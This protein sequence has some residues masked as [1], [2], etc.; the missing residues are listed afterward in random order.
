MAERSQ[1]WPTGTTGDGTLAIS[2][3]QTLEWFRDLFTPHTAAGPN[4]VQGILYG[5]L[6]NLKVTPTLPDQSPVS[7]AAG[8]AVVEGF[9]Y[10]NDAPVSIAVPYASVVRGDYIVL[11]ADWS[12]RQVRLARKAGTEG[13]STPPALTQ[14]AGVTWE[15]AIAQ[16]TV[17]STRIASWANLNTAFAKPAGW[18]PFLRRGGSATDWSSPGTTN[19][20]PTEAWI[21]QSGVAAP[22]GTALNVSFPASFAQRPI[23]IASS[24]TDVVS[25]T[26]SF[27][28]TVPSGQI[29]HWLAIGPLGQS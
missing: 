14:V 1:F 29:T 24:A 25:N 4:P 20:T 21:M 15:I 11:R 7:V 13:S 17:A 6:G 3:D 5:V 19:Y 16:L 9:Y 2:Q 10:K 28:A 23:V 26:G 8:A 18:P 22:A 12:T 27:T